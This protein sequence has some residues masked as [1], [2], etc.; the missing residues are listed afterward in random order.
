MILI[1]SIKKCQRSVCQ[2]FNMKQC[3]FEE[4]L[5]ENEIDKSRLCHLACTGGILKFVF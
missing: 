2:K 5:N 4:N 3:Y 1:L